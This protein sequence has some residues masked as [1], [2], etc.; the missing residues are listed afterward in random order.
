M[1]GNGRTDSIGIDTCHTDPS[2]VFFE[3]DL[4]WTTA[5]G[6]DPVLIRKL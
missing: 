4:F 6:A 3:M 5:G 2:L 1:E